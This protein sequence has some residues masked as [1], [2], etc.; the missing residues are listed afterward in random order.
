MGTV[1]STV[2]GTVNDTVRVTSGT[3]L[4][5]QM[6]WN[7]QS[8]S[9]LKFNG[10]EARII[11]ASRQVRDRLSAEILDPEQGTVR[12]FLEGTNPIKKGSYEFSVQIVNPSGSSAN[13]DSIATKLI[14]LLVE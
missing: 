12:V 8:G 1:G 7:D 11:R 5:M 3:D 6:T 2:N 10:F 4:T 14:K 9:P 13:G